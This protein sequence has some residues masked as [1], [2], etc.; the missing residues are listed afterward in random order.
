MDNNDASGPD[1]V[2]TV[3]LCNCSDHGE[4][5]FEHSLPEYNTTDT[6]QIVYCDCEPQWTGESDMMS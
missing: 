6:F 3:K 2:I 1:L 4:C 5:D